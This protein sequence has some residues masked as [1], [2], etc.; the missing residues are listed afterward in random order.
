MDAK[1]VLVEDQDPPRQVRLR[2]L[3][4]TIG[5]GREADLTLAHPLVSRQHCEFYEVD[6][7]LC[8]KDLGSLNGTFVGDV[9]IDEAALESEDLITVGSAT[10]RLVISEGEENTPPAAADAEDAAAEVAQEEPEENGVA[11]E[12][13][14][15]IETKPAE[16]PAPARPQASKST[17]AID[18][19]AMAMA[20]ID[21]EEVEEFAFEPI[22]TEGGKG[23]ATEN[24]AAAESV[25]ADEIEEIADEIEEI[26]KGEIEDME[27]TRPEPNPVAK[28]ADKKSA[29]KPKPAPKKADLKPADPKPAETPVASEGATTE[30]AAPAIGLPPSEPAPAPKEAPAKASDSMVRFTE[31]VAGEDQPSKV[32]DDDLADFFKNMDS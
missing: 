10:F 3:P 13:F 17:S 32:G 20:E 2:K 1:L 15:A 12:A 4:M 23:D 6:G 19:E 26:E 16:K 29:D 14:E 24:E 7:T 11:A 5:R 27:A 30:D 18:F 25:A 8:V 31:T 21:E 28:A 9:R 22:D